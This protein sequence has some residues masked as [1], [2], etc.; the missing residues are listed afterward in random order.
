[1]PSVIWTISLIFSS[2]KSPIKFIKVLVLP[3]LQDQ[4]KWLL[5]L[6]KGT[7]HLSSEFYVQPILLP[8]HLLY[9]YLAGLPL[10]FLKLFLPLHLKKWKEWPLILQIPG[11]PMS[12]AWLS[13]GYHLGI[14]SQVIYLNFFWVET[15][16]RSYGSH[17]R[18]Q[19]MYKVRRNH[20]SPYLQ[21]LWGTF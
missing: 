7:P 9:L 2:S 4:S 12:S 13:V 8:H 14:I 15:S 16:P 20:N 3:H 18:H 6:W 11:G 21:M 19:R 5:D 17:H 10:I 1:M